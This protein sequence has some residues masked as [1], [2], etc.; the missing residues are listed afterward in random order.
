MKEKVLITGGGGFIGGH[1][2]ETLKKM[3]YYVIVA[4]KLYHN[5][6]TEKYYDKKYVVDLKYWKPCFKITK[7]VDYVYNLAAFMGG[8]E[9]V[10]VTGAPLMNENIRINANMIEASHQN[11][12]Q[13]YFFSSS[14]C[15]YPEFIQTKLIKRGIKEDEAIPAG[16][17]TYYGW[18]KL[19][20]EK[21]LEAYARDYK[22]EVRIA[23]FHNI[24]G[25]LGT[26][27]GGKE[28]F[29]AACCRKVALVSDGGTIEVF[30]DGK[31]IRSY[32]Y[33]SDCV[34]GII[35]LMESNY[36]KPVNIGSD[37]PISV[38]DLAYLIAN[39]AGKNIQIK[40]IQGPTGVRGRNADITLAKNVLNWS[41]IVS[42]EDGLLI[43]YDWIRAMLIK[44][45]RKVY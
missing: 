20:T 24:Y 1:L 18:E 37:R 15:A 32:C 2:A 11:K 21:M 42:L 10:G 16:P 41:P 23:R 8:M 33:I 28:K 39:I 29:P 4:D 30:G 13:R 26:F 25:P 12:I 9:I 34:D 7:G 5:Y 17:D 43:T 14:A 6:R 31:A 3:G 22:T 35:K 36:N 44:S 45:G 19:F 38:D 40:H 27:E